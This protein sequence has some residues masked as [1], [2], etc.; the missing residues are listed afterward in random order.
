[1]TYNFLTLAFTGKFKHLEAQFLDFNFRESL[2]RIRVA[3]LI[4]IFFYAI[5]GILDAFIV[6]D[7][8][9]IFWIIR[10][11]VVCPFAL[12]VFRL[13]FRPEFKKYA[14]PLLFCMCLGGGLGIQ[15]MVIMADPPAT[16]SYYAGIILVFITIFTFIRMQFLWSLACSWLIV[17]C[18]E[19]G[20]VFL[21]ETPQIIL[22]N[23][24]FFFVSANI[25]CT[26]A[27][28]SIELNARKRFFYSICLEQEKNKVTMANLELDQR[29]KERTYELSNANKQ[30]NR[31]IQDRIAAEELRLK[32]EKELNKKKNLEA[33]G[34]V[35]GGIA[36]DF[37]NIL[38]AVIMYSEAT[39][40]TLD[41]QSSEYDNVKE[42]LQAGIRAKDLTRQI[43]TFSRQV[44]KNGKPVS[45]SKITKEALKLI[46][47]SIPANIDIIQKINSNSLIIGDESQLHRIIMN[48]C[49][50]AYQSMGE[51][52]GTIEV[53]VEDAIINQELSQS[54]NLEAPGHYVKMT[55]KDTGHGIPPEIINKIFHPFFTTKPVG[56]G[57]GMGL[58]VVLG[59]VKQY[60][61]SIKVYSEPGKGTDFVV[62][63]P[64]SH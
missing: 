28:Y 43:L 45:L 9:L 34:A 31:E 10:Y 4:S 5:F 40:D 61:G 64:V 12:N 7:K 62:L 46:R 23:N 56:L 16:Y 41:K 50:N 24:N 18:Y 15:A 2:I 26:L 1:M 33:I 6:P 19:I 48:L 30:L 36:H 60:Q 29:V 25:L 57:T 47:A 3:I 17:I 52:K 37:N 8:K 44:E 55:V 21:S 51:E 35:A 38:A 22:I 42:I 59:I 32:L 53:R 58:S 27:G 20:A 49:T 13:S 14:Q 39:L 11:A 54:S 63:F